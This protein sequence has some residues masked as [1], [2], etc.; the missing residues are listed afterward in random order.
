MSPESTVQYTDGNSPGE[1][2]E[3]GHEVQLSIGRAKWIA[4]GRGPE[5]VVD[6]SQPPPNIRYASPG[7]HFPGVQVIERVRADLVALGL[8]EPDEVRVAPDVA[9]EE[10]ERGLDVLGRQELKDGRRQLASWTVIEGQDDTM[11]LDGQP[12]QHPLIPAAIGP[13]NAEI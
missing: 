5:G 11:V 13:G 12:P 9:A 4:A 2:I 1:Q 6:R 3:Q 8:N 7:S 10:K